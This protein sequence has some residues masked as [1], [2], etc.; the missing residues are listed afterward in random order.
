M[1][2]QLLK[3]LFASR[4]GSASDSRAAASVKSLVADAL[5]AYRD[6]RFD[7]AEEYHLLHPEDLQFQFW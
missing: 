6:G 5:A 2:A 7:A 4:A 1:L 3:N